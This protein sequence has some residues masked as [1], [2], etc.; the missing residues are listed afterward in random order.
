MKIRRQEKETKDLPVKR[1]R[2]N[3]S[4]TILTAAVVVM[5]IMSMMM[6]MQLI[7]MTAEMRSMRER[8]DSIY[9][10]VVPRPMEPPEPS[11]GEVESKQTTSESVLENEAGTRFVTRKATLVTWEQPRMDR[12]GVNHIMIC[13]EALHRGGQVEERVQRMY[14]LASRMREMNPKLRP[15]EGERIV[16]LTYRE[17]RQYDLLEEEEVFGLQEVESGFNPTAVSSKGAE[18]LMQIMPEHNDDGKYNFHDIAT[19]IRVGCAYLVECIETQKG[20]KRKGFAAY[21]AGPGR[22]YLGREYAANVIKAAQR[23]RKYV[24]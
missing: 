17:V 9:Q 1:R 24:M 7:Q 16:Y 8:L 11:K 15:G 22:T 13:R 14:A 2:S 23:Y 12:T 19:N 20:N 3:H 18:G 10:F 6:F 4:K 21:Y 5:A